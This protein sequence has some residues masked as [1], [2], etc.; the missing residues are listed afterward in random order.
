MSRTIEKACDLKTALATG[1][2]LFVLFYAAWCPFSRQ[3]LPVYDKHA[4]GREAHFI[5][6]ALDGN[7][8]V[9]EEFAIDVYPTV[10]FFEEGR[11]SK[12]LDGKH[13]V[14]LTEKQLVKLVESCR[15]A[16]S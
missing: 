1:D 9:F 16:R 3:F 2:P 13:F 6:I 7:E 8:D 4:E 15:R 10:L 14:G 5:R 11:V 12:R